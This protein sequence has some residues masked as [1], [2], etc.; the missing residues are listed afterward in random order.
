MEA[1]V[2][3]V[4]PAELVPYAAVLVEAGFELEP[5]PATQR[6]PY[7]AAHWP[8]LVGSRFKVLVFI[9]TRPEVLVSLGAVAGLLGTG[10]AKRPLCLRV[11][12]PA[13]LAWLLSRVNT[14]QEIRSEALAVSIVLPLA[15]PGGPL[16]TTSCPSI[17]DRCP[18]AAPTAAPGSA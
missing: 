1:Q 17:P 14:L 18:P 5:G 9:G 4:L 15:T 3:Y 2:P 13:E 12:Q 6:Y 16:D 10:W 7:Q 8:S 11:Q